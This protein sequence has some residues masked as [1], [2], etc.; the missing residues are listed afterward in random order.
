MGGLVLLRWQRD[1][2]APASIRQI[3]L[4]VEPD[5]FPVFMKT[6]G[7]FFEPSANVGPAHAE[8]YLNLLADCPAYEV[9]GG[10]DFGGVAS[11][12]AALLPETIG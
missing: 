9:T 4:A 11:R 7:L 5:L 10:I 1:S 8:Q 2:T 12:L 3:D 6:P